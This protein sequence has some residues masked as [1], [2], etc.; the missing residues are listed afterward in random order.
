M[1][2]P[3]QFQTEEQEN[4][5]SSAVSVL[6]SEFIFTFLMAELYLTVCKLSLKTEKITSDKV[7][8]G[9]VEVNIFMKLETVT[10]TDVYYSTLD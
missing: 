9:P 3:V 5:L 7:D 4:A 8:F 6:H 2:H 10:P 1:S